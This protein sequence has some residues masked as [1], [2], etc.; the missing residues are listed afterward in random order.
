MSTTSTGRACRA[1]SS[2]EMTAIL[3]RIDAASSGPQ[4]IT[5]VLDAVFSALLASQGASLADYGPDRRLVPGQFA[6][7]QTQWEAIVDAATGRGD[8]FGARVEIAMELLDTMPGTYDDSTAPIPPRARIDHR[9]SEH[10]VTVSRDA[11][12]VIAAA[13]AHCA[14]LGAYFGTNS[15]QYRDATCSWQRSLST[16][17]SMGLGAASTVSRDGPLSLLVRTSGGYTYGII[18]HPATRR[19]TNDGCTT[20]IYDTGHTHTP[21]GGTACTDGQHTPA[22]PLDAPTPGT[23]SLHS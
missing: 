13:S 6:I 23:W 3:E 4:I 12:D 7:P 15:H 9:P 2:A 1:L 19:C 5:T 16:L 20:W 22:Y 8:A 18:F 21:P 10:V 11:V 17:F 14:R